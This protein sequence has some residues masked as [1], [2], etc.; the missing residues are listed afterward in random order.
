VMRVKPG[1]MIHSRQS[2][3]DIRNACFMLGIGSLP[4]AGAFPRPAHHQTGYPLERYDKFSL[5]PTYL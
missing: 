4:A 5:F 3:E 2:S 1:F